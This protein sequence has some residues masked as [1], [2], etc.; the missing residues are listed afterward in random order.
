ME[1]RG[2][3][4]AK[5]PSPSLG[6][7]NHWAQSFCSILICLGERAALASSGPSAAFNPQIPGETAAKQ[8]HAFPS[9]SSSLTSK[10]VQLPPWDMV[11]S[12]SPEPLFPP[13][14]TQGWHREQQT[15][16]QPEGQDGGTLQ[17]SYGP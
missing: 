1:I 15:D 11:L 2:K 5:F 13:L 10:T 3:A 6:C 16:V 4:K 7:S 14:L 12:L 8:N 9:L 17:N